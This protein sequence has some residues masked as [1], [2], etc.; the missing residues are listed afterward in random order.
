MI[1]CI[2]ADK[3]SL[4]IVPSIKMLNVFGY[5]QAII[6]M[7]FNCRIRKLIAD[8]ICRQSLLQEQLPYS[9]NCSAR[10]IPPLKPIYTTE[11]EQLASATTITRIVDRKSISYTPSYSQPDSDPTKHPNQHISTSPRA[12]NMSS[13][14]DNPSSKIIT[15]SDILEHMDEEMKSQEKLIQELKAENEALRERVKLL[16]ELLEELLKSLEERTAII[17]RILVNSRGGV[18]AGEGGGVDTAQDGENTTAEDRASNTAEE[19]KNIVVNGGDSTPSKDGK[20]T[21]AENGAGNSVERGE[22]NTTGNEERVVAEDGVR[23][24]TE[25]MESNT[26]QIGWSIT[27]D[28]GDSSRDDEPGSED[29][30]DSDDERYETIALDKLVSDGGLDGG[31]GG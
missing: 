28:D 10:R 4:F 3:R 19:R 12:A 24:T 29:Y 5:D 14:N 30:F 22:E 31:R 21:I 8:T 18:G 27:A 6:S 7:A 20:S 25:D 11:A 1:S 15:L 17:K 2:Q 23:N 16:V 9:Y 13:S 26:A